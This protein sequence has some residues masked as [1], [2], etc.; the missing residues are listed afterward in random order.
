MSNKL[1]PYHIHPYK[2]MTFSEK[3]A[4]PF[5]GMKCIIFKLKQF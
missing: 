5:K 2:Y 3:N 1:L 4:D